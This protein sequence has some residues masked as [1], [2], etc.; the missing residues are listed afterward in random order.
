LDEKVLIYTCQAEHSQCTTF[1]NP[2]N[3]RYHYHYD[4]PK[5]ILF[6]SERKNEG[7]LY[8]LSIE[9]YSVVIV[10]E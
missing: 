10:K 2:S 1:F 8:D 5:E 3:D 9:P 6:D 4:E 7:S